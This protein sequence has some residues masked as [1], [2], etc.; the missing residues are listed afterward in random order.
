MLGNIYDRDVVPF[1][2]NAGYTTLNQRWVVS[3]VKAFH[4]R[5]T[6][7]NFYDVS[8]DSK[9]M[10]F[11][12]MEEKYQWIDSLYWYDDKFIFKTENSFRIGRIQ[13]I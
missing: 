8:K 7:W 13:P 3:P 9:L 12:V 5:V 10:P 11:Q 1:V 6:Y 2:H 4:E